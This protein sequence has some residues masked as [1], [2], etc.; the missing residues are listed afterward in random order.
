MLL[1]SWQKRA[2]FV[3]E[4]DD[5]PDGSVSSTLRTGLAGVRAMSKGRG[6]K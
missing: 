6:L 2:I 1:T 5:V 4:I 3:H